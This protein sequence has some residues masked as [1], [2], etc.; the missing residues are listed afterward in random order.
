MKR[1]RQREKGETQRQ[2][3]RE[4]DREEGETQGQR[5]EG[6]SGGGTDGGKSVEFEYPNIPAGICKFSK[7]RTDFSRNTNTGYY[8]AEILKGCLST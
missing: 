4:R 8:L 5:R 3:R 7:H 1:E 6:D 2:R